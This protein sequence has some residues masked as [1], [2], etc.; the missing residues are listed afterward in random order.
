MKLPEQQHSIAKLIYDS[1]E[2]NQEPPRPHLG[3]SL[4]GEKCDR[5][6]WLQ[7]RWAVIEKFEG[8]ILKLFARGQN[9]EIEIFNDLRRIGAHVDSGQKRVD[10]GSHVSGSID[11]IVSR[12]YFA[13]K[14]VAVLEC[15]THGEKSFKDLVAKGLEKSK[16]LHWVQCH[17]Y[18]LGMKMDRSLYYGVNKNTDEIYT[19]WLHLDK[20]LAEKS[21]ERGQRIAM[22]DR[23][24]E[25]ISND[26]SWFECKFCSAYSFCHQ[27]QTTKETNCRTCS[28]STPLPDSTWR[29]ERHDGNDIPLE[30]QRSGCECHVLHPDTVLWKLDSNASSQW[31]ATWIIDGKTVRNGEPDNNIYSSKELLTN[32]DACLSGDSKLNEIRKVFNGRITA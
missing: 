18:M 15:K 25:P 30:Y 17:V 8:R 26:P 32:L 24:P 28:H 6:L 22:T 23:M 20:E 31:D 3:C 21:V 9:E 10:F 19:E 7:F 14:A 5:K 4:L 13:P 29:C 27:T 12:L 11:G 1:Y 16:P 2:Q